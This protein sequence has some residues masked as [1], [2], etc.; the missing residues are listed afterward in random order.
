MTIT[1]V[2]LD[3]VNDGPTTLISG[4]W[5][6]SLIAITSTLLIYIA[7]ALF[8]ITRGSMS[9]LVMWRS[10]ADLVMGINLII[11]E[12]TLGDQDFVSSEDCKWH[13]LIHEVCIMAS[14]CWFMTMSVEL[15][16][17]CLLYTSPSPTRPY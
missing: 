7:F 3:D 17:A 14:G 5:W 15:L 13:S 10:T 16:R 2:L 12:Y 9:E 1:R 6:V 11:A 8:P 4:F